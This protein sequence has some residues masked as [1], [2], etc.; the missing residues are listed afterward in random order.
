MEREWSALLILCANLINVDIKINFRRL[1]D[2][3]F[4]FDGEGEGRFTAAQSSET[5]G[6]DK[7]L[8]ELT[9]DDGETESLCSHEAFVKIAAHMCVPI[10][11]ENEFTVL[12]ESVRKEL[13]EI[14][15]SLA[16][17]E[18]E[19]FG[20]IPVV[21]DGP[22]EESEE[23]IPAGGFDCTEDLE[24]IIGYLG[25]SYEEISDENGEPSFSRFYSL[26]E[27][28]R[29]E[30]EDRLDSGVSGLASDEMADILRFI[31]YADGFAGMLGG[32][33]DGT[34]DE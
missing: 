29:G 31:E 8:V 27:K 16:G 18:S 22:I 15:Y 10:K 24:F 19:A 33:I 4:V 2:G 6:S 7:G 17:E 9:L 32:M 13:Y 26:I 3:W 11:R 21:C 20:D 30:I 28:K 34:G 14:M 23:G 5:Q 1:G 12:H 25:I